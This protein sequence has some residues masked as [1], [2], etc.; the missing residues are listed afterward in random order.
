MAAPSIRSNTSFTAYSGATSH[1]IPMPA[2]VT[3]G[4]K[5]L[6]LLVLNTAGATAPTATGWTFTKISAGG[7]TGASDVYHGTK[8]AAGTE[9]GTNVT[10][11]HGSSALIA[12]A[13]SIYNYDTTKTIEYAELHNKTANADPPALTPT[14]GSADT[15]WFAIYRQSSTAATAGPSGYSG[16]T[17]DSSG[18]A[19]YAYK[20]STAASEN[21]GAFTNGSFASNEWEVFTLGI[22][23]TA[24]PFNFVNT[25]GGHATA[26]AG[27]IAT[28]AFNCTTGNTV[29]VCIGNYL[30]GSPQAVTQVT[31]TAGNTYNLCGTRGAP[32]SNQYLE[33]WVAHN[34]TGNASNV[35]TA[36][37]AANTTYRDIIA[38]QFEGD[39]AYSASGAVKLDGSD[40]YAHTPN[41]V[42]TVDATELVVG[43]FI[44]Q[45]AGWPYNNN[46]D[47]SITIWRTE[48]DTCAAGKKVTA[49]GTYTMEVDTTNPNQQA[50]LVRSF[51]AYSGGGT[52]AT[53]TPSGVSSTS[54][55]GA[56]TAKGRGA[57]SVAGVAVT[58]AAG[59]ATVKGKG[60]T[61]VSGVSATTATGT[62]TAGAK[63]KA[64]PAGVSSV[65]SLGNAAAKGKGSTV[66]YGVATIA[67]I[68]TTV[69]KGRAAVAV[70]GV[71]A[72]TAIGT[73]VASHTSGG[74]TAATAMPAGVAAV[75]S[76]GGAIAKGRATIALT[77]VSTTATNGAVVASGRGHALVAG[78]GASSLLG[79]TTAKG[80]G[81][82]IVFGMSGHSSCG[83]A[84]GHGRGMVLVQGVAATSSVGSVYAGKRPP[85]LDLLITGRD[86][87][88][89]N[90]VG[91][92]PLAMSVNRRD[93][94]DMA[95]VATKYTG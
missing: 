34:I 28:N 36:T 10:V 48:G 11:S 76:I 22:K 37:F 12:V 69:S 73:A 1:S 23:G 14:W 3:S 91:R 7:F 57:N 61:T 71:S 13:F 47:S 27:N 49:Q 70:Q 89:L 77:G 17:T 58:S 95:V 90:I 78:V 68:G 30:S 43:W 33:F 29:I 38:L 32:D 44:T 25:S 93:P 92:D 15:L 52:P 83:T 54:A 74:G 64:Q 60:T 39:L 5:L 19:N 51:K 53:A 46:G 16:F 50:M 40:V 66:P 41:S 56:A 24:T 9:G 8:T 62:A 94:L 42:T 65:T 67:S 31:D 75:S 87:L 79:T 18:K 84:A 26:S 35:V 81:K 20:T 6:M 21:P 86:P 82:A 85:L 45:N 80:Q 2:T 55:V 88:G 4:D 63:G 72:T 59:S